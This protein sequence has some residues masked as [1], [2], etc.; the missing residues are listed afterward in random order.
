MAGAVIFTACT[1]SIT[2][3]SKEF[4]DSEKWGKVVTR[5]LDLDQFEA[6]ELWAPVD[7]Q[8]M[9][10]D[11]FRVELEGNERA[12]EQYDFAVGC[13]STENQT[14]PTLVVGWKTM[15]GTDQIP[16]IRM[17]IYTPSVSS[18]L[19]MGEGDIDMLDDFDQDGD[20]TLHSNGSGDIDI[21]NLT[22]R[23]VDIK[24]EGAG[25][26]SFHSLEAEDLKTKISGS[27]DLYVR[28][29][30]IDGDATLKVEGAGDIEGEFKADNVEAI[31]EGSGDVKIEV[32]C[33][34]V[35][36]LSKGSGNVAI[37]GE[38]HTLRTSKKVFGTVT[39]KRLKAEN[40]D[41]DL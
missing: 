9:Q 30:D 37:E 14:V 25:D 40:V 10:S 3:R 41:L 17:R 18:I 22:A 38:A 31:S 15:E 6:L 28:E 29:A 39:T 32:K 16:A 7:I 27:G 33:D 23:K 8:I 26:L 24:L 36:A 12:I 35:R 4:R 19:A 13:D 11:T 2:V 20:L 34:E 5:T 21:Y 1:G